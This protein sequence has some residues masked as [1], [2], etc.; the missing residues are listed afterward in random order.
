MG[1]YAIAFFASQADLT[2]QLKLLIPLFWVGVVDDFFDMT[3]TF[4][5]KAENQTFQS[6]IAHCLIV[7]FL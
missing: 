1:L 6:F 7:V 5:A 4:V 3:K 2:S